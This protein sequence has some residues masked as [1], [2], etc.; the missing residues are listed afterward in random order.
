MGNLFLVTL[1][2]LRLAELFL[3][4]GLPEGVLNVV[5][6][7]REVLDAIYTHPDIAAI[8]FIG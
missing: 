4:A 3:E 8:S 6:G 1:T 7:G 5:H 2:S